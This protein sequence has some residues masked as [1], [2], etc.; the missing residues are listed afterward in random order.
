MTE[1]RSPPFPFAGER[2]TRYIE[3][4]GVP[5]SREDIITFFFPCCL[6]ALII[7]P[8]NFPF[9]EDIHSRGCHGTHPAL[10]VLGSP[11]VVEVI[12]PPITI[13]VRLGMAGN[14]KR[15]PRSFSGRFR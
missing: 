9:R 11:L 4:R 14:K 8:D 5:F 13:S 1:L 6:S 12:P 3:P 2:I 7:S 10:F 15:Q